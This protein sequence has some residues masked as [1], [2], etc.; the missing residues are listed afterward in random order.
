MNWG[1][2]F[3]MVKKWHNWHGSKPFLLGLTHPFCCKLYFD[4]NSK[5]LAVKPCSALFWQ[6]LWCWASWILKSYSSHFA[7]H[8]KLWWIKPFL[9][10][11]GTLGQGPGHN[12]HY[13]G[14]K[15]GH[16]N[17][18]H[19]LFSSLFSS[20]GSAYFSSQQNH[21]RD[22][23]I[24][25]PHSYFNS[26][27]STVQWSSCDAQNVYSKTWL[28]GALRCSVSYFSESHIFFSRFCLI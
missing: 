11:A 5:T 25:S 16:L 20:W 24:K 27:I 12:N 2:C 9:N 10:R 6:R 14:F 23:R 18:S 19:Y 21:W 22:I 8:I 4:Q 7:N 28:H 1:G 17:L 13:V 3:F 15:W 26:F